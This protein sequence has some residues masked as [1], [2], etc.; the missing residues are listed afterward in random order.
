MLVYQCSRAQDYLVTSKRDTVAGKVKPLLFGPEKKVQITTADKKK[1]VYSI[2]QTLAFSYENQVYHPV[3]TG[4]GYEYMKL[5][6]EGYLSLYNYQLENQITYDGVYLVKKDGSTLDVPNLSFKKQLTKFLSDCSEVAD[7]VS[8][9]DLGKKQLDQIVDAY[10]ECI[11]QRTANT[12]HQIARTQEAT[13]KVSSWD[14]LEEKLKAEPEFSGKKDELD[15]V[16]EVK[17]K[18]RNS[19]KVPNFLLE[20]LKSTL[21]GTNLKADLDKAIEE[22]NK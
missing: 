14:T 11:A 22:V 18:I 4:K 19:E 13:K 15:M 5:R 16:A 12:N 1:T 17:N 3:R 20:G 10:N 8:S 6:K 2:T 9:G 7:R 21:G